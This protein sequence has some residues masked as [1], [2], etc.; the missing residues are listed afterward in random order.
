MRRVTVVVRC[1]CVHGTSEKLRER[2]AVTFWRYLECNKFLTILIIY[3]NV[4]IL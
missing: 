2:S 3:E 4:L 1:L